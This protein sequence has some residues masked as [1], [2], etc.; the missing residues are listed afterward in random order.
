M[1][2]VKTLRELMADRIEQRWEVWAGQHPH[3]AAAIDRTRFV[4]NAVGRLSDD[5]AFQQAVQQAG[6]DEAT[7][8]AASQVVMQMEKWI[9]RLLPM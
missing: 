3:L 8:T 7:L 4:E 6:V 2:E 9:G 1:G 5:P